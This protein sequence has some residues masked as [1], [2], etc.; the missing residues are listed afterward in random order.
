MVKLY[1]YNKKL[2]KWIFVDFGIKSK[3]EIYA[4]LGYVVVY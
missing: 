3:A 4:R 2:K 1:R